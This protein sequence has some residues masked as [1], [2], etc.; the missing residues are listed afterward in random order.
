MLRGIRR[1]GVRRLRRAHA[2]EWLRP[3]ALGL[4]IALLVVGGGAGAGLTAS[5]AIESES[6]PTGSSHPTPPS[7]AA[8]LHPK[9]VAHRVERLRGLRFERI[10]QV[11]VLG[12]T[13]FSMAIRDIGH[14]E[15][16]R[17]SR[18]TTSSHVRRE[19]EAAQRL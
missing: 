18:A 11:R 6:A 5:G 15:Q 19:S 10:P 13:R 17:A 8:E 4:L 12:K 2:P 16:K 3:D 9:V 7:P 14:R 1:G